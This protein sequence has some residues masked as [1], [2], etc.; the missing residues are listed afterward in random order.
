[1]E[2]STF[3]TR[4]PR[5]EELRLLTYLALTRGA[6][7]I[8]FFMYQTEQGWTG[9][10]DENNRPTP[11]YAEVKNLAAELK[12]L[13]PVML[14]L[15]SAKNIADAGEG[16]EA[17]TFSNNAGECYVILANYDVKTAR[18]VKLR[19]KVTGK[20]RALKD[21]RTGQTVPVNRVNRSIESKM[22]LAPGDG[23][24]LKLVSK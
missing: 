24:V 9:M 19:L 23:A 3:P 2:R 17:R 15:K 8:V 10:V 22:C 21:M 7:G 11:I 20:C 13:A 18:D 1:M 4:Y 16:I 5:P 6:K 12:T 14:S